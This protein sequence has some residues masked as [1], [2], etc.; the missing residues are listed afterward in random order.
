MKV[1]VYQIERL[2]PVAL[3]NGG[4]KVEI[5]S[6]GLVSQVLPNWPTEIK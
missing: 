1:L 2:F 3:V 5:H 4:I 6:K